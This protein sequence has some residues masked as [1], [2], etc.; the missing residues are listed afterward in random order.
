MK[1]KSK[2]VLDQAKSET[3][4]AILDS[5]ERGGAAWVKEWSFSGMPMNGLTGKPYH[6]VNAAMLWGQMV[7]RGIDD[8]R[9]VTFNQAK[10][11]GLYVKKGSKSMVIQI[12]KS[13]LFKLSDPVARIEQPKE[14]SPEW[15]AM[16]K[17]GEYGKRTVPVSYACVF[18]ATQ[19]EGNLAQLAPIPKR[20]G[21]V[22]DEALLDT[23]LGCSPCLVQEQLGDRAY[24]SPGADYIRMPSRSEFSS[25]GGFLRTLLHEMCH[26]TGHPDR[27]DREGFSGGTKLTPEQYA[28]EEL[29]A[30]LGCVYTANALGLDLKSVDMSPSGHEFEPF[31]NS[32]TYLKGW[33]SST[34]NAADAL[35][36]QALAASGACDWLVEK[37]FR[38]KLGE[39]LLH[40]R[41]TGEVTEPTLEETPSTVAP[42]KESLEPAPVER[43]EPTEEDMSFTRALGRACTA[44]RWRYEVGEDSIAF[45]PSDQAL[46]GIAFSVP[47][48]P[49]T[50]DLGV[51]RSVRMS[52]DSMMEAIGHAGGEPVSGSVMEGIASMS[53]LNTSIRDMAALR[54]Y[55]M[56]SERETV[57]IASVAR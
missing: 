3:L 52:F 54:G 53:R 56:G 22:I 4:A 39:G 35:T 15:K 50:A 28:L 42:E 44:A 8:P 37:C 41:T 11:L 12:C 17:S 24:Y 5:M 2:E 18:S 21:G 7:L 1:A 40:A 19:L 9:F 13:F 57:R 31:S 16:L 29:V 43:R 6:G 49:D 47:V 48:D 34:G 38:P 20:V 46:E 25:T 10:K 27:L 26:S 32:V 55:D 30:E 23:I 36:K 33:A 51:C 14:D 45:R